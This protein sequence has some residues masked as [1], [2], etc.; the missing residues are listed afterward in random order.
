MDAPVA[1]IAAG[2]IPERVTGVARV[3]VADWEEPFRVAVRVAV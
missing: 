3:R 2:V 1:V